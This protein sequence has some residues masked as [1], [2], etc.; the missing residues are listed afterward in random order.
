M[1]LDKDGT[2]TAL[3]AHNQEPM[4]QLYRRVKKPSATSGCTRTT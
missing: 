4:E 1:N 2:C 3:P